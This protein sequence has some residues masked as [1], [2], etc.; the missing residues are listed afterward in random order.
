MQKDTEKIRWEVDHLL[1][2]RE[3]VRI[4]GGTW[5]EGFGEETLGAHRGRDSESPEDRDD[6]TCAV[7]CQGS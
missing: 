6:P 7:Q 3:P 5:T 4:F 1:L 2:E